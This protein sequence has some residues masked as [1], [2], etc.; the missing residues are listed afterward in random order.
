M[1]KR[2]DTQSPMY[3]SSAELRALYQAERRV[4]KSGLGR[5][6]ASRVLTEEN[7]RDHKITI[8]LGAPRRV[9]ADHWLCPYIIEGIV[10]SGIHYGYGVDAL[11]SLLVALGGIRWHLEQTERH[12]I[13]FGDDHGLPRQVPT[14]LGKTFQQ[15]M[16][17]AIERESK[18]VFL[19]RLR[20]RKA[21]IASAEARL[22]VLK[23]GASRRKEPAGKANLKAEIARQE[24][25][26][27]AAKKYTAKWE[28]NLRKWQP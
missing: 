24:A 26:I 20:A 8:A 1:K 23:K 10:E 7:A 15:R 3:R 25:Q 9:E 14:G 16:E 18:R 12:F 22:K 4:K 5:V 21:E 11:Q 6:I 27:K 2:A 17:R 19:G 28:A 13:W